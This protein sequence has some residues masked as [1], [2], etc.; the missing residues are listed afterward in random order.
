MKRRMRRVGLGSVLLLLAGCIASDRLE[1]LTIQPD[2][3]ADLVRFQSNIRSTE[4][5]A[6]ADEE[7]KEYTHEFESRHDPDYV[8]ITQAGGDVLESRWL[9]QEVPY[10]NLLAARFPSAA[11]LEKFYSNEAKE[12][13]A[14]FTTRFTQDGAR[15]RLSAVLIPGKDFKLPEPLA[16]MQEIRQSL[17]DGISET[18]FVVAH[19]QIVASQGFRVA[20]DRSSALWALDDIQEL[21]RAQP[22][23]VEVFLEWEVK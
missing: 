13:E 16:S 8:R 6:K 1:T 7:L 9:R 19:G 11:A 10:A 21:L 23:R 17:A 20:G 18:R 14:K 4:K 22:D 2:G 15:R 12:G 5:G 3:S